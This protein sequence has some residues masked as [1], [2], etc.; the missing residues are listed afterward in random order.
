[1]CSAKCSTRTDDQV[2]LS[3]NGKSESRGTKPILRTSPGRKK[4]PLST[5]RP[6]AVLVSTTHNATPPLARTMTASPVGST[7]RSSV[8]FARKARSLG[9]TSGCRCSLL[10]A[11]SA[12]VMETLSRQ[13]VASCLQPASLSTSTRAAQCDVD[14]GSAASTTLCSR[15][16]EFA[17]CCSATHAQC[18]A[19]GA[20]GGP[21]L[22]SSLTG[23][24]EVSN[25]RTVVL[26]PSP[27]LRNEMLTRSARAR[28][29]QS[30]RM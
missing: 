15:E 5:N 12:E 19:F 22:G 20:C 25:F 30:L 9:A 1:M 27:S 4:N 26:A 3:T 16:D 29:G 13:S 7:S 11:P 14:D 17:G 21:S 10:I 6:A 24:T 8:V 2:S 23:C 28:L 18:R